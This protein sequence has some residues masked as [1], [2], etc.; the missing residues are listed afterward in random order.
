MKP[1]RLAIALL[2][3]AAATNASAADARHP[4]VVELFESQGCSSCPPA[5]ANVAAIADRPDILALNFSV[6]YLDYLGWKD[7]FASPAYTARQWDYARGLGHKNVYTPQVV[8]NGRIDDTGTDARELAQLIHAGER[9]AAGPDI[10]IEDGVA[11]LGAGSAPR[12]GADVWL[13]RYDPRVIQV[14]IRRGENGG[15]T[16]PHKNVVKELVRLGAWTGQATTLRLPPATDPA[17]KTA[18]FIQLPKGGQIL[19]AAKG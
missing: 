10:A 15:R 3:A 6:T 13:A 9:G 19:A 1:H 8:V 14:P 16:L 7:T 18:V 17:L 11:R 2:V 4:V 5:N 12:Q